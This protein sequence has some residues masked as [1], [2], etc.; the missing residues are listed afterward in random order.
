VRRSRRKA[1][2]LSEKPE[3]AHLFVRVGVALIGK[4]NP[5]CRVPI[6]CTHGTVASPARLGRSVTASHS[7]SRPYRTGPRPEPGQPN[8]TFQVRQ[9]AL[10]SG[11]C[12][13]RQLL[14]SR[15]SR[16]G[17]F[18]L[19][20]SQQTREIPDQ[21]NTPTI[22]RSIARR[23]FTSARASASTDRLSPT[24]S[25]KPRRRRSAR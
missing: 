3:P 24:G 5:K 17:G 15:A 7:D 9:V 11:L 21:P 13:Q 18:F 14:T 19:A 16:S 22:C 12:S 4:S 6:F 23:R 8:P 25:R 10:A 20:Q 2:G 1:P